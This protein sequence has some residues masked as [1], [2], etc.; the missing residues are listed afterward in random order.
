[1]VDYVRGGMNTT[2]RPHL[3][4][5]GLLAAL[6]IGCA[7]A[8][9]RSPSPVPSIPVT[10]APTPVPSPTPSPRTDINV[11]TAAQ[12]AALVFASDERWA[13]MSPPRADLIGGS[14][15]FEAFADATGF[16][17]KITV[18]QGDCQAGC[19]EKHTWQYHVDSTGNVELVDD[20]GDA[21]VVPP[22][23]GGDGPA[24][25]TVQL[26]A[27]PFC[28]VETIPPDPN[29]APRSVANADVTLYDADGN[30][31]ATATSDE[32]GKVTFEV[33]AGAYY[34]VAQPVDG[35]M[36]TPEAQPFAVLGGDQ[37]ELLFGYD[38]GIR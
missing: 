3:L 23:T 15:S 25:V 29:C 28:P 35:L 24:R 6:L 7:G 14:T 36:G 8:P 18:G 16:I 2:F 19:I 21:V 30:E 11:T 12:A 26:S 38:T 20:S 1:M 5:C 27:G 4:L 37:A 22:A 10:P 13:R 31:V 9:A 17:V 32:D 33:E 34:A